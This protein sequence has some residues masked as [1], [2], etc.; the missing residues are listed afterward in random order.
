MTRPRPRSAAYAAAARAAA[1]I[2]EG[3]ARRGQSARRAQACAYPDAVIGPPAT[4]PSRPAPEGSC[5][6]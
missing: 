6:T 4:P 3:R 2:G 1:A 5:A